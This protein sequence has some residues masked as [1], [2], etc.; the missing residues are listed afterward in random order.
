MLSLRAIEHAQQPALSV[1]VTES[2]TSRDGNSKLALALT[3]W[4][5]ADR[6]R[7]VEWTAR[8]GGAARVG[9][10]LKRCHP[11]H[12]PAGRGP[13]LCWRRQGTGTRNS[14]LNLG[15]PSQPVRACAAAPSP[16]IVFGSSQR[17]AFAVGEISQT[18]SV[19]RQG[20]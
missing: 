19:H 12:P 20:D 3:N 7:N 15:R 18:P 10:T 14:T 1:C 11:L 2:L 13:Q 4:P 9:E 16:M 17:T 5:V 6:G 8:N